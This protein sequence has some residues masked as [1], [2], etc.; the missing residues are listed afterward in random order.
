MALP[1]SVVRNHLVATSLEALHDSA[2]RYVDRIADAVDALLR[3][4]KVTTL[5]DVYLATPKPTVGMTTIHDGHL[6]ACL[7]VGTW[8]QVV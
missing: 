7:T 1:G 8:T 3:N 2:E 4:T 5:P 6:Y